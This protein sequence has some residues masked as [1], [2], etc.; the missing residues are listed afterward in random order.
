MPIL[1]C[2]EQSDSHRWDRLPFLVTRW[3][4][5]FC[6]SFVRKINRNVLFPYNKNFS[7]WWRRFLEYVSFLNVRHSHIIFQII[8]PLIQFVTAIKWLCGNNRFRNIHIF[9]NTSRETKRMDDR[10]ICYITFWTVSI[11]YKSLLLIRLLLGVEQGKRERKRTA[12]WCIECSKWTEPAR[13]FY[14]ANLLL[15]SFLC[16]LFRKRIVNRVQNTRTNYNFTARYS[17]FVWKT[18][19]PS[20]KFRTFEVAS[21]VH[22]S[23]YEQKT[24]NI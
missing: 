10:R 18:A 24:E 22:Y 7:I 23:V 16:D 14:F 8:S 11:W 17:R 19:S 3:I 20:R 12:D 21:A 6:R 9:V 1:C 4:R 13:S 15:L 5:E 2:A